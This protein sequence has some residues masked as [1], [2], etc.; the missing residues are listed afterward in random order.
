MPFRSDT[1]A[2]TLLKTVQAL[3]AAWAALPAPARAEVSGAI[4]T[5]GPKIAAANNFGAPAA[6]TQLLDVLWAKPGALPADAARAMAAGQAAPAPGAG[7]RSVASVPEEKRKALLAGLVALADFRLFDNPK[8]TA[9]AVVRLVAAHDD[10][11]TAAE[12]EA[13]QRLYDA[14][15]RGGDP[16]EFL[17][18]VEA[19]LGDYPAVKALLVSRKTFVLPAEVIYRGAELKG[20]NLPRAAIGPIAHALMESA[21][22]APGA[23]L[24]RFA[25]VYFPAQVVVT[26]KNIPLIIHVAGKYST[27]SALS[28]AAGKMIL[29]VGDLTIV[30]QAEGFDVTEQMGGLPAPE[31]ALGRVV[32]VAPERDCEPVVFLLSPQSVGAKRINIH[33]DQFG[34]NILTQAIETTVVA[35]AAAVSDLGNVKV[36][37][38]PVA[39]PARGKDAPA[40][41]LELRIMLSGDKRRLSFMLNGGKYHHT[42]V[43]ESDP[44]PDSPRAFLQPMFDRLDTLAGRGATMRNAPETETNRQELIALGN[45]LFDKLFSKELKVEYTERI[46]GEFAGRGLMIISDEPWIP[47]EI[48]RPFALDKD[49]NI[50]YDDPPLCEMFH[51]SRW[52]N[53]PGAPDQIT[54]RQGAWVAPP[55]SAPEADVENRYFQELHRRQ[56]QVAL[57]GPLTRS[58]EI[59]A[60][61]QARNTTFLHFACHGNFDA[62]NPDNSMVQ[63]AGGDFFSPSKIDLRSRAGVAAAKPLVFFNAC[64]SGRISFDLTRLGGWAADLLAFGVS[65]FVGSLWA[66]NGKL[67]AQFAQEF[68][69]RLWGINGFE[70]RPQPLGQAFH[71]ARMKIKEADEANPTWLAYVLYGDPY[72]Q[73]VLGNP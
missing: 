44:L 53:G 25:N 50:L 4:M 66:I 24:V 68:Y 51:L 8:T 40:P 33:I 55:S 62:S 72:G 46:R 14:L 5:H 57:A 34:R 17:R 52:L 47:W 31:G 27:S 18:G 41:D 60:Q 1:A 20:V 28:E 36:E 9:E 11:L 56:W 48:V 70:G 59:Q 26:Q 15:A 7:Y 22:P 2:D 69:N 71:E 10:R 3:Q 30:I 58:A 61:L 39:S 38:V 21:P 29:Q 63:L 54:M 19:L 6:I 32:K 23:P 42:Q 67:A 37:P 64:H 45:E 43:G 35:E 13:Y 65:A 73:V 16:N 49:G 12:R